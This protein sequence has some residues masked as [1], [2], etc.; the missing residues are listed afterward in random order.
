MKTAHRQSIPGTD[1][2][3]FSNL[4]QTGILP[5]SLCIHACLRMWRWLS[6]LACV[7]IASV[8]SL[9]A[10]AQTLFPSSVVSNDI[11]FLRQTDPSA[12]YCL[13]YDGPATREMVYQGEVIFPDGVE[14]FY[15]RFS[16]QSMVEIWVH[17]AVGDESV[18][19]QK[20][21]DLT[22]PLGTLPSWMRMPGLVVK[23]NPGDRS[24]FAET[25]GRFFVVSSDNIE[26]R[27][28]THD[29][30]ETVFHEMIHV[31]LDTDHAK[32]HEWK[33]AQAADGAFVTDYALNNPTTEDLA[34]TALF[35]YAYF[36][37]PE[38]LPVSVKNKLRDRFANRLAYLKPLLLTKSSGDSFRATPGPCRP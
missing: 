20:A 11:D 34:E 9:P 4:S 35:A 13:D 8:I 29:L 7:A 27:L 6:T 3:P 30:Q 24:A 26:A 1:H 28:N 15:A 12:F 16:D 19:R 18:A 25:L 33:A 17:P 32:A 22:L 14:T 21:M 5:A 10:A 2:W 31:A 38:R 23:I 36:N 37:H